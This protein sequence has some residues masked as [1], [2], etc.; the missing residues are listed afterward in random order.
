MSSSLAKAGAAE[1]VSAPADIDF[2]RALVSGLRKPKKAIPSRFLYDA[3]G[4]E[5]FEQI[6]ELDEYYPT[7]TEIAILA[8][9]AEEIAGLTPDG[10]AL[11]EFGSGSSRK[12]EILLDRLA[13]DLAVYV[14]IDISPAALEDA[15]RRLLARYPGL[16]VMTVVGDFSGNL[17]L[18]DELRKRHRLGFFPGSTIGNLEDAD[19]VHLL[20]NMRRLLGDDGCL[21]I[22]ADLRKD[23]DRLIAAYDDALGVTAAFNLNLLERANREL[24]ADFDVEAFRHSA[25]WDEDGSRMVLELVSEERQNVAVLGETFSFKKGERIHTEYSHKY[26]IKAFHALAGRAGWQP[27]AVWTDEEQLFSVHVLSAH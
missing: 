22:G 6:T 17:Q 15:K 25:R 4:S 24:G 18:S 12:T 26:D 16:P 9:H 3:R 21:V 7:R 19:A 27:Q 20:A 5:L 14:A 11:I 23:A 1:A 10:S 2:A 13:D 8:A